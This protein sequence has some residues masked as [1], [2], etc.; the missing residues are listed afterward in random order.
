MNSKRYDRQIILPE[1]GPEGQSRLAQSRVLCIG[2]GGLGSPVGLY[3]AA[4]GVGTIGLIDPD[5]VDVSNL[6]RQILFQNTDQGSEKVVAAQTRLLGLNP[7]VKVEIYNEAFSANNAA[8]L[9]K[10]YDLVIDGSDNFDTKFL[11]SDACYQAEIP[12]VYGAVNRFEGQVALFHG[13]RGACYRCL[14]PSTPKAE[15][16]NCAETGVL[17]SVVGTIGTL[18]CTLALQYLIAGGESSHPLSPVIGE[19]TLFDL[20]G[21]WSIRSLQVAKDLE[22]PTCSLPPS[23]IELKITVQTC[24]SIQTV[25]PQT[26]MAM[27]ISHST[28]ILL[29]D[30]RGEDEWATGHIP[31]AMHWPLSRILNG[32]MPPQANNRVT[33][34]AYCRSGQ[35]SGR[36][37]QLLDAAGL[38]PTHSLVGGIQA[39]SGQLVE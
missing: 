35:R 21:K 17:G 31:G 8:D 25:D 14:Y 26:L 23:D 7:N 20:R 1:I 29:L 16:Q 5:R 19:L 33:I 6:Q 30:V 32:E 10:K 36:A 34:I 9:L 37:A 11:V 27:M 39:W 22:C 28:H 2:V 15:V 12:M 24:S 4:A 3:L 38:S 18:Q 13:A